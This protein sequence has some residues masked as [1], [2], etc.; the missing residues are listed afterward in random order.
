MC[1]SILPECEPRVCRVPREAVS[2]LNWS[3][4]QWWATVDAGNRT[5]SSARTSSLNYHP[6]S[7]CQA[8]FFKDLF[9]IMCM[10]CL[11]VGAHLDPLE[12]EAVLRLP[13]VGSGNWTQLLN[14]N[15]PYFSSFLLAFFI[16]S[17]FLLFFLP[18]LSCLH[19]E[20][21]VFSNPLCCLS[22]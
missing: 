17:F 15:S 4:K 12:L 13:H 5:R 2:L 9:S 6:R 19:V 16:L 10:L 8:F 22:C 20:I 14:K 18:S 21:P 11:Y 3:Y 1:L 7:T